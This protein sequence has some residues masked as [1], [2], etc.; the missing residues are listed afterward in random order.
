MP[1]PLTPIRFLYRARDLYSQRLAVTCGRFRLTYADFA[2]LCFQ[3]A[4]ALVRL[5]VKPGDRVAYLSFNNQHLLAGYFV[6]HLLGAVF[7]PLNARLT[8]P[9]LAAILRRHQPRL[10]LIES[11]FASVITPLRRDGPPI[12]TFS[13]LPLAEFTPPPLESID[14]N[15]TGSLFFTSGS[16]AEP[17]AVPMTHRD[18][19][20][21]ALAMNSALEQTAVELHAIPLYHA[22]GWGRPHIATLHGATH[23]LLRR[24]R[25]TGFFQLLSQEGVTGTSLVPVMAADLL[26]SPARHPGVLQHLH[27]GGAPVPSDLVPRLQTEF[28]W[29]ISAGYGLTEAGP[30]VATSND[31][32]HYT[33]I[34]AVDT[35]VAPDGELLVRTTGEW[36]PTGDLV[37]SAGGTLFCIFDRK[38]DVIIS[39]G[40]NISSLEVE[41]A[42]EAHPAVAECAVVAQPDPRWGETPV[43]FVVPLPGQP[44]SEEELVAHLRQRL[45]GFKMPSRFIFRTRALPRTA[46][47]KVMKR[48]LTKE[49]GV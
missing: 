15:A 7:L 8:V 24:F 25:P 37:Q 1:L 20:V 43:A 44:A 47:G 46:T 42:L 28:G 22:N 36:F 3:T 2:Q 19:A 31:G 16:T 12:L 27:L 34:P 6:P 38:K 4:G 32:I 29:E 35:R 10:L 17:T 45:A 40:E 39:G 49:L 5:G 23:V 26:T 13:E 48:D 30:V 41:T 14:E 33:P 11:E 21:H 9:E 18:L